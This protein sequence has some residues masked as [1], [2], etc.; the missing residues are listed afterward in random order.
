M[1]KFEIDD[2]FRGDLDGKVLEYVKINGKPDSIYYSTRRTSYSTYH[3]ATLYYP[4][5]YVIRFTYKI[6]KKKYTGEIIIN[7]NNENID[8]NDI[9]FK[10]L[11]ELGINKDSV[12]TYD[13]KEVA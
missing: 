4:P 3:T 5:K 12:I 7:K 10:R 1:L 8:I 9:I 6:D 2:L 11:D 13:I